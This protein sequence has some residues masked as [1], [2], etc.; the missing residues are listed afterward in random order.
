MKTHKTN[1]KTSALFAGALVTGTAAAALAANVNDMNS[2]LSFSDL[3][4]G[5]ELR[6]ELIE[7][8][9]RALEG[10]DAINH[11]NTIKFSE[12]KCGEGSCGEADTE[13][14]TDSTKNE[15][16]TDESKCGEGKCGGEQSNTE[17]SAE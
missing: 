5:S 1:L 4:T 12:L 17:D 16:K 14:K 3:G 10:I 7:S 15:G 8:N 6:T 9:L 11:R 2:L 13:A